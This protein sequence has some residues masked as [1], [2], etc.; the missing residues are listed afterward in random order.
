FAARGAE[1]GEGRNSNPV[2]T[3]LV[4]R[5][6]RPL[7]P[8]R[9]PLQ[10]L[11]GL[12]LAFVAEIR[13]Q[14]VGHLP[15]VPHLLGHH[16]HQGEQVVV[17]GRVLEQVALLL[18]RCELGI[19]LV[20]DEVEQGVAD[21][22]VGDVHHAGP[23][24]LSFVM[25]ELDVRHVLV[26]EL[27][28][29]L[30]LADL[31]LRQADR[32]LPVAEVVDP[33]V[34][35]VQLANHQRLPL[36]SEAPTAM[37]ARASGLAID[38]FCWAISQSSIAASERTSLAYSASLARRTAPGGWP[39]HSSARRRASIASCAC[40]TTRSNRPRTSASTADTMRAL[41]TS[42]SALDVPTRR[43]RNKP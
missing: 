14:Q 21:A 25:A 12:A 13:A 22:L 5:A 4:E 20:H 7:P 34:E 42:S 33:F 11:R 41:H 31:A 6:A 10:Q 40:G 28:F 1:W 18:H 9:P 19:A 2:P 26:P 17:G 8:A 27:R 16:A 36:A 29:E 23:L 37:R 32:V 39:A 24:A 30:E 38:P 3:H 35:V 43:R 15:A